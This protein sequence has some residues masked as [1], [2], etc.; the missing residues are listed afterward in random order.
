[1]LIARNAETGDQVTRWHYG[2]TLAESGVASNSLLRAKVYPES[3]DAGPGLNGPDGVY[4]RVEYRYNRQGEVTGMTDQ[5]GTEHGYDYDGLRRL[6][7]DR[8]TA[9]GS[10]IDGRVRRIERRYDRAG[11]LSSVAS[12]DAPGSG[13]GQVVNEVARRYNGFGQLTA[14]YQSHDGPFS[15]AGTPVVAYRY[16]DGSE[17]HIRRLATV[18][19]GGRELGF[20][21]GAAGSDDDKLGRVG[22]LRENHAAGTPALARYTRRGLSATMRVEY[23]QCGGGTPLELTYIKQAGEPNGPAGDQ[24]TGQDQFNRIVDIR[25]LR[26]GTTTHADRFQYGFDPAGNRLW[27]RNVVAGSGWDEFYGYDGLYQLTERQR[28]TLNTGRTGLTGPALD[29]EQF[30]FDPTGNRDRYQTAASGTPTLDQSRV[31]NRGNEILSIDGSELPAAYDRAG[32]MTRMP[33][34][35][36]WGTVQ[37]AVWDAWNRLAGLRPDANTSATYSYDGL[38]RRVMK[39]V[40][41]YDTIS[42]RHFY[43]SDQWQVLEE[44]TSGNTV[45][46]RTFVWGL[47]YADDLVQRERAAGPAPERLYATHDQWHVTAAAADGT[48]AE[49]YAFR[50]F[51]ETQWLGP[52]F[53]AQSGSNYDWETTYGAYRF[54]GESRMY[55]VRFRYLH[56][57]LGRWVSRDPLPYSEVDF[58]SNLVAYCQNGPANYADP[59]G[60]FCIDLGGP[61]NTVEPCGASGTDVGPWSNLFGYTATPTLSNDGYGL[62]GSVHK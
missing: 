58:G 57:E 53:S 61:E 62:G 36:D 12:W 30:Y 18:Y 40:H 14:E 2:T 47:R 19:P 7:A 15:G 54:D 33:Q 45:P 44:R 24:Y 17:R 28:G 52:D 55:C 13:E 43:Y 41:R 4:D 39:E 10:G 9:L 5:N 16:A 25:W 11:R 51:G 50:A 6:T 3:D 38:T 32:N 56:A 20:Y 48:A 59:L 8:V 27:R 35:G 31:H 26:S 60:L 21:Y 37:T 46:E 42:Q 49:R 1:M 34:A 29:Q 23:P 22:E